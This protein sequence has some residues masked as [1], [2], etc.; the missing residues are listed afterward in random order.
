MLLL[1][2]WVGTYCEY[3][4][5]I[6][7]IINYAKLSREEQLEIQCMLSAKDLAG[8][9]SIIGVDVFRPARKY[10]YTQP[11]IVEAMEACGEE[12]AIELIGLL[13][14]LYVEILDKYDVARFL[15]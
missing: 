15:V 3:N 8:A 12:N 14:E 4:I 1:C 7:D 9:L 2:T 10:G 5:M 11:K 6:N 13:E